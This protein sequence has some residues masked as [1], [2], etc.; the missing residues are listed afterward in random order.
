VVHSLLFKKESG[1]RMESQGI[2]FECAWGAWVR[3]HASMQ[4]CKYA[5]VC[6]DMYLS[7]A[8]RDRAT[9]S[10]TYFPLVAV[11]TRLLC[12]R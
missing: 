2:G 10:L 1:M 5:C 11:Y 4:V 3:V 12:L 8:E 9:S 6:V 7:A